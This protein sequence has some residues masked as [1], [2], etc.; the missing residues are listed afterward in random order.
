MEK[1]SKIY[2]AGHKGLVGSAITRKLTSLGYTN[3]IFRTF[4]ELNLMDQKA[5]ADFFEIEKPEYVFL[6]A[7]KVGGIKANDDFPADFI[8][9]NLQI[10]NNI[11]HNAYKNGVKKLLFL[12]S[13][14]IYP[15]DC[16]QPIKEEYFMTGPL[17]K[18]ND[19]YAMAK[20]AGIKMC[21]SYNKQYGTKF[22]A[23]MPTNLYGPNDNFDL[24]SSHVLPALL[25]KFHDAKIENKN[26]VVM[27]GTGSP[28]REFLYV[29]DLADACVH[30]MN[31]YDGDEI[32]NIGT[33]EDIKIIELANLIKKTV[34]FEGQIVKDETKPDG[35]P[36]K[37]LDVSRLH[38]LGWQHKTNLEEGLKKTYEWF[39]NNSF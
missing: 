35:T 32:V 2:V 22:I 18:T 37:L 23:V 21:Q 10:Q 8:F 36:R 38:S 6:A 26:E 25:R 14:C 16:A 15:R 4:E 39:L 5:T 29:D 7:A 11:I 17:E 13:S 20:I 3:L 27:W 24:E 33:G 19:A 9:Q 34:G 1:N 12:G 30:L 28:M 31:V